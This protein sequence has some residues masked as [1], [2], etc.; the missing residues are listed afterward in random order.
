MKLTPE[1]DKVPGSD[2]GGERAVRN[3]ID[4]GDFRTS[5]S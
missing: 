3:E 2:S 1:F 4:Q 5:A